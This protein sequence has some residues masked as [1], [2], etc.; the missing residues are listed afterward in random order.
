MQ[1]TLRPPLPANYQEGAPSIA[2]IKPPEQLPI[3]PDANG[4]YPERFMPAVLKSEQLVVRR[5]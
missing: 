3:Q 4:A 5:L 1:E 2:D